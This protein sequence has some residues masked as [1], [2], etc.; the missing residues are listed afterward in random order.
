MNEKELIIDIHRLDEHLANQSALYLLWGEKWADAVE[1]RDILKIQQDLAK[2]DADMRIRAKAIANSE[3]ITEA[4]VA[5][6]IVNDSKYQKLLKQVLAATGEVNRLS[7]L[8]TA[9]EQ[10][11]KSLEGLVQLFITGYYSD[12]IA[13]ELKGT[14]DYEKAAYNKMVLEKDENRWKEK[15]NRKIRKRK[16]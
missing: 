16:E 5:N 7:V 3:K 8:K 4:I 15:V 6:R 13:K 9:L 14:P 1:E 11:K 10:R 12:P 2:A